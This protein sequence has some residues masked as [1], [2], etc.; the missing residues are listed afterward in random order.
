MFTN[1][2][3]Y[4]DDT[5]GS[6]ANCGDKTVISGLRWYASDWYRLLNTVGD[7][8]VLSI[9]ETGFAESRFAETHFAES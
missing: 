3:F 2:E 4:L 8:G 1:F 9:L 5:Q 7:V 6:N